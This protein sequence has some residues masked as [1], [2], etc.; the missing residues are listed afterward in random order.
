M[1]AIDSVTSV[2]SKYVNLFIQ[3][4]A[5]NLLSYIHDGAHLLDMLAPHEWE[6]TYWWLSLDVISLYTSIPHEVGLR[7]V[8]HF[9]AED[10]HINSR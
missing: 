9:L 3:P 5:Q 2:F 8:K 7:A 6:P 10:P 4:L 1:A